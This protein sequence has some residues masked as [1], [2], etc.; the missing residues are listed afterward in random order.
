MRLRPVSLFRT[1]APLR[2]FV[3]LVA[4]LGVLLVAG[5]T[6]RADQQVI[7]WDLILLLPGPSANPG[8][9]AHAKA[10]N[11]NQS[12]ETSTIKM[13]GSGTFR[14]PKKD[15]E[16]RHVTGGGTW[17]IT[18]GAIATGGTYEVTGVVRWVEAPGGPIGITDNIGNSADSRAGLAVLRI[19]YDDGDLGILVVSCHLPGAPAT[20]VE[21]ISASKGFTDFWKVQ[22]PSGTPTTANAN[23]TLFHVVNDGEGD[24]DED[25]D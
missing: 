2:L 5:E 21:G 23:R 24:D 4:A 8:G 25:E 13:T 12:E 15:K 6:V 10:T 3:G 20:I 16:E 18:T 17:M 19:K 9:E 1:I 11:V 22:P 14:V 7:R